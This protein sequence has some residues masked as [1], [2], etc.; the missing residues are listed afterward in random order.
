ML[1]FIQSTRYKGSVIVL[2]FYMSLVDDENEKSI[3]EEL[4]KSNKKKMYSIAFSCLRNS[5]DAEDVVHEA[6][7][8]AIEKNKKIFSIP[9]NKRAPYLDVIV[10]NMCYSILREDNPVELSGEEDLPMEEVFPEEE[11]IS[12]ME[13][14]RLIELIN[15]LPEGQRDTMYLR[16]RFGFTDAEIATS[17]SISENAVRNRIYNARKA[18]KEKLGKD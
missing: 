16:C 5:Q 18:M 3:I 9:S 12:N 7:L 6:F 1:L 4:Y 15:S 17:L 10:R 8:V 14:E 13:C 2:A 11:A